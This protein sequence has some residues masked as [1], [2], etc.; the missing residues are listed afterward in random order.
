MSRSDMYR[1]L[2]WTGG[3]PRSVAE[4]VNN[5][6]EGKSNNTGTITLNTGGATTTTINDERIGYNSVVLL[7][8]ITAAAADAA[9]TALPYGAWQDS[10]TQSASSTT[11]AYAITLNT[12]DYAEGITIQ[13]GSQLKVLYSGIYN[14]QFS[15]QLSNLANSTENVDVWFRVNGTDVPKSNS[16]FG[17]APRK[18]STDPYH[19]IA[20]LNY[21]ASLTANDY[22][23]IM[24]ATSNT[25]VTIKANGTQTSPTR[26]S[27]PSAIV[28]MQYVS[29]DGYSSGLFGGVW[30]SSTSSG[31][32]VITHPANTLSGK[33]YRYLIVA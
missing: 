33:T 16:M 20:A 13:S 28:T 26:P 32:A 31:S 27:T 24:W 2:P 10:T 3:D 19:V 6:V 17:L 15:F 11:S 25:S 7:M 8:P 12:T 9:N 23:Q 5:L 14:I 18:T 1:K 21:F 22:I 30:V 4:I 29:G